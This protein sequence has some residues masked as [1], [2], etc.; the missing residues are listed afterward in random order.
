MEWFI[1][2]LAGSFLWSIALVLEKKVLSIE[3]SMEYSITRLFFMAIFVLFLLPFMELYISGFSLLLI[4][5]ASM[6]A[7]FGIIYRVKA[8]RH[9]DISIVAPF[10]NFDPMIVLLLSFLFLGE[11]ITRT[12][13]MGILIIVLGA[14][15]LEANGNVKNILEPIRKI[16][17]SKYIHYIFFAMFFF[18]IEAVLNKNIL[19]NHTNPLLFVFYF[20]IFVFFNFL[21]ISFFKYDG[22]KQIKRGLRH[23]GNWVFT[24]SL[25]MVVSGLLLVT[26]VS[27]GKVSLVIS[28]KRMGTVFTTILGGGLFHDKHMKVRIICSLIM[29]AGAYLI[30]M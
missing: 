9:L 21:L 30:L 10:L 23:A 7:T 11:T 24:V 28:I 5:L 18:S 6:L 17:R 27:L 19:T 12:Q 20:Y 14:Y 4:Y 29:F 15:I 26:A 3:H 1:F 13:F 25:I 8:I 16:F 22:I 2:A